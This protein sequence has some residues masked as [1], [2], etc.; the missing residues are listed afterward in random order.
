MI[1]I[2]R[3]NYRIVLHEMNNRFVYLNFGNPSLAT[4][5]HITIDWPTLLSVA[6]SVDNR[7]YSIATRCV[8]KRRNSRPQPVD[9]VD[10]ALLAAE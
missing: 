1:E 8:P 2:S 7:H 4:F 5:S 3:T 10:T 9:K 6:T